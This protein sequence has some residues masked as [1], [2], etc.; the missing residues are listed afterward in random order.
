VRTSLSGGELEAL[1]VADGTVTFTLAPR[2][3]TRI[4]L[5]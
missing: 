4:A 2:A 5:N 1:P 3:W